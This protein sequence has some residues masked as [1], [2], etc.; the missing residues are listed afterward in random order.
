MT[1]HTIDVQQRHARVAFMS[2]L[3]LMVPGCD[4]ADAPR[5][6]DAQTTVDTAQRDVPRDVP[7]IVVL[8]V[9]QDGGFPQAGTKPGDAWR[10][11]L[12]RYATSIAVVDPLSG[13]RWLFEATP[14]FR[15]Q[16]HD[17]D[18][19]AP[20][21]SVPGLA[22]VFLTHAHVGHYTGLMHLGREVIG[23]RGVPVFVMPRM[24]D[25]LAS[26]GP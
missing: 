23:A 17:L 24:R 1:P 21:T 16:L 3:L 20:D 8:G 14:D 7:Y 26:N 12:R 19:V 9:G 22:G 4:V 10:P 13:E 18:R 6:I 2:A 25:F 15:D 5:A 11:A